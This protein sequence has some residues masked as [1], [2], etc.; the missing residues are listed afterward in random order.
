RPGRWEP[1]VPP[2]AGRR[3]DQACG[4]PPRPGR[5]RAT[6]RPR[7]PGPALARRRS[8][9][10]RTAPPGGTPAVRSPPA[11]SPPAPP[12][13]STNN[14]TARLLRGRGD[15]GVRSDACSGRFGRP[16][17]V[18]RPHGGAAGVPLGVGQPEAGDQPVARSMGPIEHV[19]ADGLE[20]QLGSSEEPEGAVAGNLAPRQ[21][22]VAVAP[23]A[24]DQRAS[25]V[26]GTVTD[27]VADGDLELP[28][29]LGS[30]AGDQLP[31]TPGP[32]GLDHRRLLAGPVTQPDVD[33]LV[34]VTL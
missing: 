6:P 25:E 30:V 33:V 9:R 4:R 11:Q 15:V 5:S 27:A 23:L 19:G 16:G 10:A 14:A 21:A 3:R 29:G 12:N 34:P 2:P 28:S 8:G 24:P 18:G 20:S 31:H 13:F 7:R 32:G 1:A 17:D 26:D 22:D